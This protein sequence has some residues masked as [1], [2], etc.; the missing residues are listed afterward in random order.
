MENGRNRLGAYYNISPHHIEIWIPVATSSNSYKWDYGSKGRGKWNE[1][2]KKL[3]SKRSAYRG[4]CPL[5][6]EIVMYDVEDYDMM[7]AWDARKGYASPGTKAKF[8]QRIKDLAM[9]NFDFVAPNGGGPGHEC[10][11]MTISHCKD[12]T[13]K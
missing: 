1:S 13:A 10:S 3:I 4:K 2:I 12:F 6:F 11:Y 5:K 9:F 8:P 7:S